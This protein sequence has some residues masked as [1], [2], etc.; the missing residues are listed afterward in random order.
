MPTSSI[1]TL[2]RRCLAPHSGHKN[3]QHY[4]NE[5]KIK[6]GKVPDTGTSIPSINLQCCGAFAKMEERK[7]FRFDEQFPHLREYTTINSTDA[8]APIILG[9]KNS[10]DVGQ[11]QLSY[12]N[13][14]DRWN[15]LNERDESHVEGCKDARFSHWVILAL[16]S[17]RK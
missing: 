12:V 9:S 15:P 10:F 7:P 13:E 14:D 1:S 2:K 11:T 4:S 5:A 3:S 17:S 6:F 8:E 16:D